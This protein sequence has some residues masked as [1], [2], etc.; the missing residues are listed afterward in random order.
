MISYDKGKSWDKERVFLLEWGAKSADCGYPSS[1]Q[2]EDGS[3]V[4]IY[5]GVGH[6]D[7]P[8]LNEYAICVR[9]EE[10]NLIK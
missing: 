5:Y 4:T 1:V 7:Y 8:D 3:I 6:K 9:Y 2:L 10:D